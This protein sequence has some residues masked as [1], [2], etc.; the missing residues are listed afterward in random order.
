MR[1]HL[2]LA[3]GPQGQAGKMKFEVATRMR[4]Y[5]IGGRVSEPS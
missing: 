5:P 1:E 3:F 2:A 4:R